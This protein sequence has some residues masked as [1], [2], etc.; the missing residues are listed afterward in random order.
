MNFK[1]NRIQPKTRQRQ[2]LTQR[3]VAL[4][5][6]FFLSVS[7][8]CT[9]I[10]F[11]LNQPGRM[12]AKSSADVNVVLVKDHELTTEKSI[13]APRLF[14]APVNNGLTI[15]VRPVVKEINPGQNQ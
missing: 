1:L 8:L 5:A 13:D 11:N 2:K 4:A 7:S 14:Q 6:V 3:T 9:M 12:Q 15:F 10:F